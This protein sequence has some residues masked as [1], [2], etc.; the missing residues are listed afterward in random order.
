MTDA[1]PTSKTTLLDE[2][3]NKTSEIVKKPKKD[4]ILVQHINLNEDFYALS[5]NA[6]RTE[7]WKDKEVA[8]QEIFLTSADQTNL[9][10]GFFIFIIVVLLTVGV[11]LYESFATDAYRESNWPILILRI[12]LVSFSQQKLKPE[13]FQGISLLRYSFRHHDKFNHPYFAK[14]VAFCQ[15]SIAI[16]TFLA[17]FLFCCMADEALE[18]IMNFAGL[19]VISELDDWVGEQIMAEKLHCDYEGERFKNANLQ[20]ENLND[21]MGLFTK[22]CIIGEFMELVDDQ[23]LEIIDN[24]VYKIFSTIIDWIP[25]NLFPLLTIPCQYVLVEVQ[26]HETKKVHQK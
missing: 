14:F 5:W 4:P 7:A 23:N 11:L 3:K 20:T 13:V 15:S 21:R 25:W 2:N 6:C 9:I 8:G 24:C 17:I 10:V 22:L 1:D 12:T 16:M 19:A 18:L 26:R